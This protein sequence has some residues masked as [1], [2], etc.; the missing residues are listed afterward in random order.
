MSD[1]KLNFFL[2]KY[3]KDINILCQVGAHFGQELEIFKKYNFEKILLFEPNDNAVSILKESSK[4]LKNVYIY[5]FALGNEN[6]KRE[7]Y[8]S[9]EN[10][11]QSSSFLKPDLHSKLQPG[12]TFNEKRIIQTRR[13][14]D[15]D[16][17]YLDFLIMDVQGFELEVLK[18]IGKKLDEV[19]YIYTE[20]NRDNLYLDNVLI[21]D[22]DK[23]LLK[24]SFVR[25]WASWRTADM[26]WGDALYVNVKLIKKFK[27]NIFLIKNKL[28]TN[29]IYFLLF[30]FF[31]FRIYKKRLKKFL[32]L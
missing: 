14:E 28:T 27:A 4:N 21:K 13:F 31:D 29:K 32:N 15:L 25:V 24:N 23:F 16:I 12:I 3:Q 8:Y 20:V 19:K 9:E 10:E 17:D 7:F 5:P 1:Q 6:K 26:P 2:N 22:L 11:G 30:S 18:G